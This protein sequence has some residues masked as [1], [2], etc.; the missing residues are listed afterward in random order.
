[1]LVDTCFFVVGSMFYAAGIN[2]FAVPNNI[3]ESGATGLAIAANYLFHVPVGV[4]NF[5]INVPLFI[6]AWSFLGKRFVGRALWVVVILSAALDL[7]FVIAQ[8]YNRA[9]IVKLIRRT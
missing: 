6:L 1:M 2:I 9:R 7:L 3:A 4:A 8:R 5:I